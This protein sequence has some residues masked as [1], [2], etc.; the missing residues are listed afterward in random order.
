[1]KRLISIVLVAL[2]VMAALVGCAKTDTPAATQAPAATKAPDATQAPAGTDAPAA[3]DAP[4]DK[5]FKISMV[6]P[7]GA[8]AA[9][10]TTKSYF[11][12]TAQE[13]GWEYEFLA[14][15]SGPSASTAEQIALA[16]GAVTKGTDC[17]VGIFY[18][19]DQY[20][21]LLKRAHENGIFIIGVVVKRDETTEEDA[22]FDMFIGF[23]AAS[24]WALHAD[25]LNGLMPEDAAINVTE[26]AGQMSDNYA[27]QIGNFIEYFQEIHPAGVTDLGFLPNE[28]QV[29]TTTE[30]LNAQYLA[31]PEMNAIVGMDMSVALGSHQFLKDYK[32]YDPRT[33]WA[34]AVDASLEN[35]GTLKAGTVNYIVDQG[36]ASFGYLSVQYAQ[37]VL[38]FGKKIGTD[39]KWENWGTLAALDYEAAQQ[40]VVDAGWGEIPEI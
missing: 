3:T 22:L 24:V 29:Q 19:A 6:L 9:W 21:D 30:K 13:I 25:N 8:G 15:I 4:A 18:E 28:Q 26:V 11:E 34:S 12:K 16:E 31:H 17:L 37:Q 1:M 33:V 35:F 2:F 23:D 14:P 10:G 36:Y 5:K 27:R 20:A 38:E 32:L 7:S 39:L 40:W